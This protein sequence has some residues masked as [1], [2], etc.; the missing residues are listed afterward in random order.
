MFIFTDGMTSFFHALSFLS[1]LP[2]F[3][4][5]IYVCPSQ[6]PFLS[7]SLPPLSTSPHSFCVAIHQ[8][9]SLPMPDSLWLMPLFSLL[10]S[11]SV[12]LLYSTTLCIH[13]LTTCFLPPNPSLSMP[14]PHLYLTLSLLPI[15]LF[16]HSPSLYHVTLHAS[17]LLCILPTSTFIPSTPTLSLQFITL[18]HLPFCPL[19]FSSLSISHW[20]P[21]LTLPPSYHLTTLSSHQ[22]S[23]LS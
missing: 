17:L 15:T 4:S 7:I 19:L 20:V 14:F 11:H 9:F 13:P 12:M 1:L 10:P 18:L 16:L 2:M 5:Y 22:S 6:S 23:S 8:S 21:L 3:S